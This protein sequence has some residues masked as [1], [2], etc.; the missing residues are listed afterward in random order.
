MSLSKHTCCFTDCAMS[1]RISALGHP[2]WTGTDSGRVQPAF[3]HPFWVL[4]GGGT[5][6][7]T[8]QTKWIFLLPYK[9]IYT[10][11][12][13]SVCHETLQECE[14][15]GTLESSNSMHLGVESGCC[16]PA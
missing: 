3:S 13:Q 10:G 8:S 4:E 5:E 9:T 12:P 11:P 7:R 14:L 16:V 2:K 1:G 15:F 6:R